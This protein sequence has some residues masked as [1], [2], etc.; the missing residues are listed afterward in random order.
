ME[1]IYHIDFSKNLHEGQILEAASFDLRT[2]YYNPDQDVNKYKESI[3]DSITALFKNVSPYINDL[4]NLPAL[5]ELKE[6]E[7]PFADSLLHE[8]IFEIVRLKEFSYLP[9]RISAFFGLHANDIKNYSE[10]FPGIALNKA[11]IHKIQLLGNEKYFQGDSNWLNDINI[12]SAGFYNATQYWRGLPRNEASQIFPYPVWELI[13]PYPLK[14][15]KTL[16]IEEV[17]HLIK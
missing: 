15:V 5:T 7:L 3:A 13:V 2:M 6:D 1:D 17:N 14:V 4:L 10:S 12:V 9:S 8:L 11:K 16:S